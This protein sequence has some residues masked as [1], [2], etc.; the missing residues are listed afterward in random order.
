MGIWADSVTVD[1]DTQA[2]AT[3]TLGVP[4]G[5]AQPRIQFTNDSQ[6][7]IEYFSQN[8]NVLEN[9]LTVSASSSGL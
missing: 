2:S 6:T 1:S 4:I 9:T 5:S 3:F 7:T 8:G